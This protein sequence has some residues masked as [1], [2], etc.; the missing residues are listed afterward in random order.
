M[1]RAELQSEL[2][3]LTRELAEAEAAIPAHTVR[4]HQ[5]QRVE[6]LEERIEQLRD[7]LS[8]KKYELI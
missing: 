8:R 1:T 4:P 2:E 5:M 3:R 7:E 6:E